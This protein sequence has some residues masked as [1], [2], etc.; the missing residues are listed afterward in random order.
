M[1]ALDDAFGGSTFQGVV[2]PGVVGMLA[3]H[4]PLV[5]Y[6][7]EV[8]QVF[9]VESGIIVAAEIIVIGLIFSSASR[10]IYWIYEGF[11]WKWLTR[12]AGKWNKRCV[13][14]WQSE[15]S[16]IYNGR[17]AKELSPDEHDRVETLNENLSDFP[18]QG[19]D[20]NYY[21]FA[22]RPTRL[23]NIISTYELYPSLKYGIDGRTYWHHLLNL[24]GDSTR[25]EFD[26]QQNFARSL[27]LTS[28]AGACVS[29]IGCFLLLGLLLGKLR[30][31]LALI[32]VTVGVR[33]ASVLGC[34][35]LLIW[36]AFYWLS[37]PAHRDASEMFKA[38]VDDVHSKFTLP[39]KDTGTQSG[40]AVIA[41]TVSRS[42]R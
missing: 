2:L 8:R 7:R 30:P 27:V 3:A 41:V 35:G 11:R 21:W 42:E 19:T 32:G 31:S 12:P 5:P 6:L 18:T 23:G 40:C 26:D 15:M 25:K 39:S 33:G 34:V 37:L 38:I 10:P 1:K 13:M 22:E 9:D 24:A 14:A 16:R 36:A 4:P 17:S 29:V 20:E 28:F